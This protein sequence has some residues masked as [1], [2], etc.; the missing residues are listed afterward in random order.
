M[1]VRALLTL[2]CWA[3]ISTGFAKT[4]DQV[5]IE[6]NRVAYTRREVILYSH[7]RAFLQNR[8]IKI[9]ADTWP[10]LLAD[11]SRDMYQLRRARLL[12]SE[13]SDTVNETF[14]ALTTSHFRQ[15]VR[16]LQPAEDELKA[17]AEV[18]V[19]LNLIK[20]QQRSK[21]KFRYQDSLIRHYEEA[22]VFKELMK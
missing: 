14:E 7:A 17:L 9:D 15:I 16:S 13:D 19:T 5:V 2:A 11:F 1:V 8:S 22:F 21:E 6:V 10:A 4:I 20:P 3:A 12:R 18:Y